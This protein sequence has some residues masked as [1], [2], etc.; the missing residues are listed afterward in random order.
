TFYIG[1][2]TADGECA[3]RANVK[4]IATT[5]GV[6]DLQLLEKWKPVKVIQS[7]NELIEFIQA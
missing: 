2:S 1:D 5:T 4:F 7:L 3:N 6:T